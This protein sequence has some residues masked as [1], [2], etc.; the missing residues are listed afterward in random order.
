M[1]VGLQAKVINGEVVWSG[2]CPACHS[3]LFSLAQTSRLPE[4]VVPQP[5][6]LAGG[7]ERQ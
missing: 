1:P 7:V 2:E 5:A 6:I 3:R 4:H